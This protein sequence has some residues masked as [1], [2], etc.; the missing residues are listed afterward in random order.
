MSLPFSVCRES[1]MIQRRHW[2]RP[3][4]TTELDQHDA[5]TQLQGYL[6]K[7]TGIH[8]SYQACYSTP[9]AKYCILEFK[10]KIFQAKLMSE[11]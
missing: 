6:G 2:K 9:V 3:V 1:L 5:M 4:V 10:G 8:V 11:N 7:Y